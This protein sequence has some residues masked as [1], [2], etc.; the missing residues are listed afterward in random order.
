MEVSIFKLQR[1]PYGC[2]SDL[3]LNGIS[4]VRRILSS[5]EGIQALKDLTTN[6]LI[7]NRVQEM[8]KEEI[9]QSFIER[10]ELAFPI[11]ILE[12]LHT[13]WSCFGMLTTVF[14]GEPDLPFEF[15]KYNLRINQSV[16]YSG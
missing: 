15:S 9:I 2:E 4:F 12:N 11:I 3:I 16:W 8:R 13:S 6:T 5:N 1:V 14:P 10:L 7:T